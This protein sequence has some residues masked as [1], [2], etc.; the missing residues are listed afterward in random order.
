M[1]LRTSHFFVA[2]EA[3]YQDKAGTKTTSWTLD[4]TKDT[5][6]KQNMEIHLDLISGTGTVENTSNIWK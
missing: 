4:I 5:L 6:E 2:K 1:F 3:L